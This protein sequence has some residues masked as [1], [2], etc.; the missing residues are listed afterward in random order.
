MERADLLVGFSSLSLPTIY[1]LTLLHRFNKQFDFMARIHRRDAAHEAKLPIPSSAVEI[2][3]ESMDKLH[4]L[5][6][7]QTLVS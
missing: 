1:L 2:I 6:G 4:K 3:Q 7:E 5:K